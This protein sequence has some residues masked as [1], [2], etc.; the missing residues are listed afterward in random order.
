MSND[1]PN[2][3]CVAHHKMPSAETVAEPIPK[4]HWVQL[5]INGGVLQMRCDRGR[6]ILRARCDVNRMVI[7]P[8]VSNEV[9]VFFV[10]HLTGEPP[11]LTRN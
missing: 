6:L 3:L 5:A 8:N 11:C 4:H 2:Q 1:H 7:Q 9:E 10:D